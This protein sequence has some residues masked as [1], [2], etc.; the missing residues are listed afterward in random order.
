MPECLIKN[1]IFDIG[2]VLVRWDPQ[3]VV[4]QFFPPPADSLMITKALFKSPLWFDLNL[5]KITEAELITIYHQQLGFDIPLLE[6]LMQAIK[7]SLTPIPGSFELLDS[8]YRAGIP[9]YA[10]TDST[11]EIVAYLRQR[12]DFWNKFQ[13]VVVSAEIGHMKPSPVIFRYLLDTYHLKAEETLFIDDYPRNIAGAQQ[14]NMSTIQFENAA[15]CA[16]DLRRRHIPM[17]GV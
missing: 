3:S 14:L 8:L 17:R 1:I 4:A 5:G 2:N 6:A 12:Y 9:L 11:K 10:L 13:G 15:A 7:E 16:V